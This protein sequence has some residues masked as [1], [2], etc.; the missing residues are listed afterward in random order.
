MITRLFIYLVALA[1]SGPAIAHQSRAGSAIC[2]SVLA[3]PE[4]LGRGNGPLAPAFFSSPNLFFNDGIYRQTAY[5]FYAS[6]EYDWHKTPW[7][8]SPTD[9]LVGF[10][11]N[12]AWDLALRKDA[13]LLMIADHAAGP[14]IAQNF[15]LRTILRFAETPAHFLAL[16][17]G[18][19]LPGDHRGDTLTQ[20][21]KYLMKYQTDRTIDEI[22]MGMREALNLMMTGGASSDEL[23]AV[24][25][26]YVA[27]ITPS[28]LDQFGVLR[29]KNAHLN[30]PIIQFF[31]SRYLPQYRKSTGFVPATAR[32]KDS[33]L[34]SPAAFTRFR[35]LYASSLYAQTDYLSE[36]FYRSLKSHGDERGYR[37][38]T[39]SLSNILDANADS[40]SEAIESL[41]RYRAMIN[42]IF[43]APAYEVVIF[44]TTNDRNPHGFLRFERDTPIN[45][46]E[47]I[48][49]DER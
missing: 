48:R 25:E 3:S 2:S 42:Q 43:P 37:R 38:Y 33:F 10:G 8:T 24:A 13:K 41:G 6:N 7:D 20:F 23:Q 31:V 32:T 34:A 16:L 29:S 14:L 46:D 35:S 9:V 21:G 44:L 27:L 49:S 39:F 28:P 11:T 47:W 4:Q 19:D 45:E 12:S 36:D 5:P 15:I 30:G 22:A 17:A 18:I 26:Y 40:K 1:I